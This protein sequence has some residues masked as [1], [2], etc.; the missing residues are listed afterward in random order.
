MSKAEEEG[1]PDQGA[2][3]ESKHVSWVVVGSRPTTSMR[4][5]LRVVITIERPF[6]IFR[7]DC[8]ALVDSAQS[9]ESRCGHAILIMPCVICMLM[10]ELS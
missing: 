2:E 5:R 9:W 1:V 4:A 6:G 10:R 8:D 3:R 7:C